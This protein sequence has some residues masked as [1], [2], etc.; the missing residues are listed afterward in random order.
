MTTGIIRQVIGPTL[1]I[2]FPAGQLPNILNAVKVEDKNG[3]INLMAEVSMHVGGNIVRC[4]ALSSTEGL[5]RGLKATDTGAPITVPV[6][7]K[8]LGRVLN[9]LGEPIDGLEAI[10]TDQLSSIHKS[11]P[12]FDQQETKATIFET[13]IKV[14]DL[15]CPYPKGGKVGLLAGLAWVSRLSS[16]S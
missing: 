11:P 6:G 4:I 14:I 9:V 10:E 8:T 15:L 1:D 5:I 12:A 7:D 2:E 13:G 16:W 3:G